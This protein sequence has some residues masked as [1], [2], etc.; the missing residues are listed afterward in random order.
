MSAA[1]TPL[2]RPAGCRIVS[3]PPTAR[4]PQKG[5]NTPTNANP[6][7]RPR[8]GK[9]IT[10]ADVWHLSGALAREQTDYSVLGRV[11]DEFGEAIAL[12]V[13]VGGVLVQF[14]LA[15]PCTTIAQTQR[16]R[17]AH[18]RFGRSNLVLIAEPW[19]SRQRRQ[20]LS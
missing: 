15:D 1:V 12:T 4:I 8:P 11:S 19:L 14:R 9:P 13:E 18:V 6:L 16:S 17:V 20:A 10:R 7:T 3:L 5:E 2:R